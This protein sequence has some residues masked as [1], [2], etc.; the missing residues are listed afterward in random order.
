MDVF[1]LFDAKLGAQMTHD[2]PEEIICSSFD[3]AKA[4]F[5]GL[6][7]EHL[8]RTLQQKDRANIAVS[9]GNTP[10][11]LFPEL[12]TYP[13]D[14]QRI[15]ITLSDERWVA[16]SD[17]QSNEAL[18]RNYLLQNQA[19]AASFVGLYQN[20]ATPIE[21]Q[22]LCE[23]ALTG[24][25]DQL[26][27]CY[28]GMGDDGHFASLFPND[29]TLAATG[30]CVGVPEKAGRVARMSLTL[31]AI[32]KARRC[33]LFFNGAEKRAVWERA[34]TIAPSESLPISILIQQMGQ[35]LSVIMA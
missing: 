3:S 4:V 35:R 12:S 33:I 26:D 32:T 8:T 30:L 24:I 21:G 31:Q 34:K 22:K 23:E 27:F 5:T 7:G 6:F 20:T 14:W 19:A 9:G 28:L 1:V 16:P 13:L 2:W 17:S 11:H 15:T 25:A 29:G 18:V 10:R